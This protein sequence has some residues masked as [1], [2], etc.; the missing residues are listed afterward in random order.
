[1]INLENTQFANRIKKT[2]FKSMME[3]S[4]ENYYPL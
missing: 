3:G 1:M 4:L 2:T